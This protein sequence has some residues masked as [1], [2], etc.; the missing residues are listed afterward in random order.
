LHR[1]YLAAFGAAQLSQQGKPLSCRIAHRH[2][3]MPHPARIGWP[4]W[5]ETLPRLKAG[6]YGCNNPGQPCGTERGPAGVRHLA[7]HLCAET[8]S[9]LLDVFGHIHLP[10]FFAFRLLGRRGF[11]QRESDL[12]VI[13]VNNQTDSAR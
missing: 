1:A 6:L 7:D 9:N 2:F 13:V 10:L 12:K 4:A 5:T 3:R 8:G 11:F